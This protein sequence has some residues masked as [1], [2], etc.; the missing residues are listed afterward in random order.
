MI[1]LNEALNWR[2]ATKKFDPSKKVKE[3]DMEDLLTALRMS[4]SSFG[5]QPW[6]F[7]VVTDKALREKLK[8]NAWGQSQITDSSH[9]I[10]LCTRKDINENHIRKFVESIEKTRNMPSGAMKEYEDMMI[11][12]RKGLSDESAVEWSKKQVYIALGFLLLTCAQKKIDAC[13]MEGFD[14]KKFDELLGL[15]K[16][17]LTSTALCA[18]GYRAQDDKYASAKKV[19]F[20]KKDIFIFK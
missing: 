20:D 16:E 7:V 9:L 14:S 1:P 4:P 5:L 2:Y 19:R 10:V 12:F 3:E 18:V 17:N 8:E 6:K 13:P 11:G 15:E